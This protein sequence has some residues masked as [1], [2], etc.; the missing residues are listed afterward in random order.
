MKYTTKQLSVHNVFP[1]AEQTHVSLEVNGPNEK[2]PTFMWVTRCE[3][4][5]SYVRNGCR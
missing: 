4:T 3:I 2:K 1:G 5:V